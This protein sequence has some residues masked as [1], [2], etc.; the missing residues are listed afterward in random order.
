MRNQASETQNTDDIIAH[1]QALKSIIQEMIVLDAEGY[2]IDLLSQLQPGKDGNNIQ[3]EAKDIRIIFANKNFA[4]INVLEITPLPQSAKVNTLISVGEMPISI[5]SIDKLTMEDASGSE[6]FFN[7]SYELNND[8]SNPEVSTDDLATERNLS[9]L[10]NFSHT[11]PAPLLAFNLPSPASRLEST[12]SDEQSDLASILFSGETTAEVTN[13]AASQLGPYLITQTSINENSANSS[14]IANVLT[15]P[16]P[17]ATTLQYSL[18][19]DAGGRFS[20]DGN[21]GAILVNQGNLLN[22]EAASQHSI[23]VRVDIDGREFVNHTIQIAL[24]NINEAPTDL[25]L[26]ANSV[27][28]NASNGTVVGTAAGV[29]ADTDETFTY[30]LLDNAGGRF[31][32]NHATGEILVANGALL[33]YEANTSHQIDVQVTDS[34]SQTFHKIFTINVNNLNEAPTLDNPMSDQA[35][36]AGESSEFIFAANTFA[37]VDGDSLNYIATKT[38]GSA[39]DSWVNFD[40]A[41]RTFSFAPDLAHLGT[42]SIMVTAGDTHG[43]SITDI[44]DVVVNLPAGSGG[45]D[46]NDTTTL[47]TANDIYYAYNGTDIVDGLAGDDLIFGGNGT[48]SLQGNL[49]NDTLYGDN[50]DDKLDGGAGIDL[51][52]GGKGDDL[53]I[54]DEQDLTIDGDKGFDELEIQ[55]SE[56]VDLSII[57]SKLFNIE[58]IDMNNGNANT[59]SLTLADVLDANNQQQLFIEGDINDTVDLDSGW[60]STGGTDTSTMSGISFDEYSNG[61][62][63][64]YIDQEI[65]NII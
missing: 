16:Y 44:F 32:I 58:H 12:Q 64:L 23:T 7:N 27:N 36:D 51:L 38:D 21:T 53:I 43:A 41:T 62:A 49:G 18:L 35:I 22:F 10:R 61:S 50:G 56:V 31:S 4:E 42:Y 11:T 63:L 39:L 29:D 2:P 40:S 9:S 30:S 25:N 5:T 65:A 14:F 3:L 8:S 48:D 46:N 57:G 54:F 20:L 6:R 28:E 24:N 52:F 55:N 37:D 47:T 17:F 26:S 1:H 34:A 15:T 59:L 45:G 19:D 60:T 33:N 13:N